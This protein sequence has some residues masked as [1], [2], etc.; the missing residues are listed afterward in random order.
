V[1]SATAS[2]TRFVESRHRLH[3]AAEW[4]ELGARI[5]NARLKAGLTQVEVSAH[6]GRDRSFVAKTERGERQVTALELRDLCRLFRITS[7]DILDEP[8]GKEA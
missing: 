4:V 3:G 8:F 6:F 7:S 5:R 2:P 1:K